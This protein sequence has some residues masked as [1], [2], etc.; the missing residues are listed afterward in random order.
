MIHQ[1]H[2]YWRPDMKQANSAAKLGMQFANVHI[3]FTNPNS[4]YH[5]LQVVNELKMIFPQAND[6]TD[7]G[8]GKIFKADEVQFCEVKGMGIVTWFGEILVQ[9]YLDFEQHSEGKWQYYW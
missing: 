1:R 8:I 3:L 6:D 4:L 7:I 9:D 5:Y 2:I